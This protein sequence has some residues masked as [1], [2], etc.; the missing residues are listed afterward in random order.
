ML[1]TSIFN[2]HMIRKKILSLYRPN[3]LQNIF[4]PISTKYH[5]TCKIYHVLSTNIMNGYLISSLNQLNQSIY[6]ITLI[7]NCDT[8]VCWYSTQTYVALTIIMKQPM[9]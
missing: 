7:Y 6:L 9:T 3:K 1:Q 2:T 8:W 5:V 4:S